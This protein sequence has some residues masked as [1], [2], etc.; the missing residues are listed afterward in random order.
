MTLPDEHVVDDHC[1]LVE[2]CAGPAAPLPEGC[3]APLSLMDVLEAFR[4]GSD[5][6]ELRHDGREVRG[7]TWGDGTPLYFLN[8]IAGSLEL[9][10]P[11]VW[12]LREQVCC[13]LHDYAGSHEGRQPARL[14][15]LV[16]DLFEIAD[17]HEHESINLYATSFGGP[18]ALEA[19]RRHP[20]RIRSVV[21]QGAF[22]HR[23]LSVA[24]RLA[25]GAARLLPGSLGRVPGRRS[26]QQH[27][28]Q[29]WFPPYDQ[30]RWPFFLEA[31]GRSPIRAMAARARIVHASDLRPYL[32]ELRQ[33]ALVIR[34]EGE[35]L[36]SQRSVE[37][38][39]AGLPNASLEFLPDCGHLP[40]LTHPHRLAKMIR[41]FLGIEAPAAAPALVKAQR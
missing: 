30:M 41:A 22:A 27:N 2:E 28:H 3:P 40:Y 35:G 1:T 18:V 38:L 13:V 34:S 29:R 4:T 6:W 31:T 20:R 21:M 23:S 16:T 11:T 8:G 7:R 5:F 26:V 19:M 33:R 32:S 24:E 25:A 36:V 14:D 15:E 10:A 9:Y 37:E 39:A 17:R 12:L